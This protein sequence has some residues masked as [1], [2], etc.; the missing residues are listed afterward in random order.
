MPTIS[1]QAIARE[2]EGYHKRKLIR[3]DLQ[4]D[5]TDRT[6]GL[7]PRVSLWFTEDEAPDFEAAER[8]AREE[9]HRISSALVASAGPGDPAPSEP[10]QSA[11]PDR[12]PGEERNREWDERQ[13]PDASWV[14]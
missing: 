10:T 9:L 11:Q 4:V 7:P 14:S 5:G 12:S 6:L 8:M 2:L 13:R 3:V 1:V